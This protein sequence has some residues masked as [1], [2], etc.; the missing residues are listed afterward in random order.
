MAQKSSAHPR[1]TVG[2]VTL[3]AGVL[4][5][6]EVVPGMTAK[7]FIGLTV[8]TPGLA[9]SGNRYK[10]VPGAGSFQIRAVD[11]GAGD[12]LVNTDISV[13]DYVVVLDPAQT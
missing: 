4:A 8:H 1:V 5:V 6:A 2:Q 3:A 10:G 13:L 9:V 7:S 11:S 12:N